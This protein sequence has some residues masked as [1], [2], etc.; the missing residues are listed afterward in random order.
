MQQ[1]GGLLLA[2]GWTGATPQFPHRGNANRFP[3]PIRPPNGWPFL[4][5][6]GRRGSNNPNA[7]VRR[8]ALDFFTG[9][10]YN[11]VRQT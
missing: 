6:N 10:V 9:S 1:S 3:Y 2:P 11:S 7:T 8:T 4:L 5:E